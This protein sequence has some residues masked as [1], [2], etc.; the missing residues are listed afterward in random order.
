MSVQFE[1]CI[2]APRESKRTIRPLLIYVTTRVT[3]PKRVDDSQATSGSAIITDATSARV[4]AL[5]GV[6]IAYASDRWCA[7]TCARAA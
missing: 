4:L 5:A 6:C 7:K 3:S 2:T 1:I